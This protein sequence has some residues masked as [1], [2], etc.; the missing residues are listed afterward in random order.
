M[1]GEAVTIYTR[2]MFMKFQEELFFRQKTKA[3]KYR[4]GVK[5]IYEV[6][7]HGK[8]VQ[9]MKCSN[10]YEKRLFVHAIYLNLLEFFVVTSLLF[11]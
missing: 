9:F 5:K 3:S 10:F 4:E 6:V 11:L 1:E 7:P 8:K 2:K